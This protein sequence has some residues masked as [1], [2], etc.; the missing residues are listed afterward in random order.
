MTDRA[1]EPGPG[2]D[3]P[4]TSRAAVMHAYRS[5][6]VLEEVALPDVLEPG[7]VLVRTVCATLCGTDAHLWDGRLAKFI[8]VA[9]PMIHGHETVGEVVAIHP[10][11][12]RDALGR[13]IKPGDRI[14]WSEATCGHC[15]GCSVLGQTVLCDHRAMGFA[16]STR[17]HPYATGG[18]SEYVYVRPGAARV[19]VPDEV[20]DSW[21]AA[22]GCAVKT[23]IR[24][25]GNGGNV[26]PGGSVVIQGAGPLGLF[27]T[28]FA[29]AHGADRVIT[30][31]GPS[32]RLDVARSWGADEV[33]SIEQEPDPQARVEL[34]RSLTGGRGAELVLD[35]AGAPTANFE[36]VQ[37]C[38]RRGNYV[39]VGISGPDALPMPVPA[40][41]G[42]EL[43]VCGSMN[44]DIA[45]L[46]A[47]L[48]FLS[49]Y[50]DRFDWSQLFSEPVGL[51]GASAALRA[52]E[53]G[54]VI[55]PVIVPA[56]T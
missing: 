55:K 40:I 35:F 33:I 29:R 50:R 2:A 6:L 45:D 20:Q 5:D 52:M 47:S 27:A 19:V 25:F 36:G 9:M 37:M 43:K 17:Q 48:R 51:S 30:I 10:Q 11:E 56:K 1:T 44:G 13:L 28:A 54:S 3:L 8:D 24:A 23:M 4:R 7:A 53:T 46:I 22:A 31:G 14:V 18:L 21:A 41:M 39:V 42:G 38:A 15:Y 34:V 26:P 49:R 12:Q 32:V 16:Q